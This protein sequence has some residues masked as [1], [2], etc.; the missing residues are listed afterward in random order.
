MDATKN[1]A[2]ATSFVGKAKPA[3]SSPTAAATWLK[4]TSRSGTPRS[5]K[6]PAEAVALTR[7]GDG[8]ANSG[9]AKTA[10]TST[11]ERASPRLSRRDL[12]SSRARESRREMEPSGQPSCLAA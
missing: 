8:L 5:N 7:A 12:S 4:T 10:E 6:L 9:R 3:A 2:D 1:D 11:A